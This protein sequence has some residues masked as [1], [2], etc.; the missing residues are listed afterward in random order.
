MKAPQAVL[1]LGWVISCSTVV[2]LFNEQM[3]YQF[4]VQPINAPKIEYKFSINGQGRQNYSTHTTR[5]IFKI[6]HKL[7]LVLI[8]V[9]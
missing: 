4:P 3:R 9:I 2:F 6:N 7:R 5:S 1:V 8:G